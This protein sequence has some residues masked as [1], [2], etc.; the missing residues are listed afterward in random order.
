MV[1]TQRRNNSRNLP[2]GSEHSHRPIRELGC[3]IHCREIEDIPAICFAISS[4]KSSR[5]CC[6][7]AVILLS[8]IDSIVDTVG[9]SVISLYRDSLAA[10]PL[11]GKQQ[12]VVT[13]GPAIV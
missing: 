4:S 1:P 3:L 2:T 8:E 7:P 9:E 5:S 10:P 13:A 11:D 6:R 12:A